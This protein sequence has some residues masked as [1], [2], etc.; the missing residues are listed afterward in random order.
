LAVFT[1]IVIVM[2]VMEAVVAL[3]SLFRT[4]IVWYNVCNFIAFGMSQICHSSS[5][6]VNPCCCTP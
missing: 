1:V 4:V 3:C 2:V 6:D 5:S